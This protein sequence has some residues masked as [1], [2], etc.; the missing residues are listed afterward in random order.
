MAGHG[1]SRS[2]EPRLA[3][4]EELALLPLIEQQAGQRLR[5]HPA[6]AVFS[7]CPTDV[8]AFAQGLHARSLWVAESA[9]GGIAGYLLAGVL[10]EDFHVLQMDVSPQQGRQG[11]GRALLRHAL[12]QGA[13][14]GHRRAVLTTL[15][16]VPWN[17]GF[18]ASEGFAVWPRESWSAAMHAVMAEEAAAGFPMALRVAMQRAL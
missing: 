10:D 16:D 4:P 15:S 14:R 5:G 9:Q 6:W 18:Y 2:P 12:A 1:P 3:R 7:A 8:A 11:H 13:G 17:A